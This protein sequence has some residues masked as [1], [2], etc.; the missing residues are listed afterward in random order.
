MNLK[1]RTMDEMI[2]HF[3]DVVSEMNIPRKDKMTLLGMITAIGYEAQNAADV[4]PVRRGRWLIKT[5]RGDKRTVCSE[6]L[7]ETGTCYEEN[8]CP[9]CGAKMEVEHE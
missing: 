8:Y 7:I 9:N 5:V 3:N 2:T 1:K 6:C 4:A